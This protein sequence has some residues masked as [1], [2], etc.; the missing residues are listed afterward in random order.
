MAWNS[1]YTSV[2]SLCWWC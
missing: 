1:W 2:S